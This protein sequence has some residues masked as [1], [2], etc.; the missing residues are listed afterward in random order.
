MKDYVGKCDCTEDAYS[1]FTMMMA[2]WRSISK[3][4]GTDFDDA[5]NY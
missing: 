5:N 3:I 2:M 1:A 4:N